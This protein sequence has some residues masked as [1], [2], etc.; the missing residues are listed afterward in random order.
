MAGNDS[1]YF[2][3]YLNKLVDQYNNTYHHSINRK[4]ILM[5]IILLCLITLS[6]M[7]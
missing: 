2:L 3:P 5:L 1:R 6:Q 4:T 7:L